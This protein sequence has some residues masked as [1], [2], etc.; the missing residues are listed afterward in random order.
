LNELKAK[1]SFTYI[2]ISHDLSVVK[3]MSDRMIVMKEGQIEEMGIAEDIY[4]NPQSEYT[5]K[6]IEAIPRV[7]FNWS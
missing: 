5:Q 4:M 2:F 1:F 3:Y 7:D 6:L